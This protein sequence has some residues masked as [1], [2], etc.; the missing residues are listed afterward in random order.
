MDI[1]SYLLDLIQTL[2]QQ[3]RWLLAFICKY[4]ML[5]SKGSQHH[6]NNRPRFLSTVTSGIV[7]YHLVS[8]WSHGLHV[9]FLAFFSCIKK[10]PCS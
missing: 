4:M 1:I 3:N 2:Y 9:H 10:H 7:W 8:F 5:G 6:N